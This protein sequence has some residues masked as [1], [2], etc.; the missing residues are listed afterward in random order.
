MINGSKRRGDKI[1][2]GP[3]GDE[4]QGDQ[5]IGDAVQ[6]G[7]AQTTPSRLQSRRAHQN[8]SDSC[9]Q[10]RNIALVRNEDLHGR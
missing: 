2:R 4:C 10:L 5:L 9:H 3:G 6:I 7:K 8:S 1:T